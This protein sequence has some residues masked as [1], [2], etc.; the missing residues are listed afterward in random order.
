M[1]IVTRKFIKEVLGITGTT[2]DSRIDLFIPHVEADFESIRGIPFD[3]DS[4]DVIEYPEN[5]EL[6]SAQMVAYLLKTTSFTEDAY[7]DKQSE[8]IGS[9]SYTRKG[10]SDM[11]KGYPK[12]IVGK[13]EQY[14]RTN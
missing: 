12:S 4:N 5:A 1:A 13:I 14:Q 9:Y 7:S 6:I 10:G 2:Y 3:E 8:S 11:L